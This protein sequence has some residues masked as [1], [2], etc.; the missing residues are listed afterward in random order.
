[1]IDL[2]IKNSIP[3]YPK[4]NQVD[5]K[6]IDNDVIIS[7]KSSINLAPHHI[8]YSIK[9]LL[10]LFIIFYYSKNISFSSKKESPLAFLNK[11]GKFSN[12]M[13]SLERLIRSLTL[14]SFMEHPA[15]YKALG[16]PPT[17]STHR[18]NRMKR[19]KIIDAGNDE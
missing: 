15:T 11:L 17:I 1:M 5:L 6:V 18:H 8:R 9:I 3:N 10:Y 16:L 4:I 14:L 13:S 2:L 7:V 19:R 12:L